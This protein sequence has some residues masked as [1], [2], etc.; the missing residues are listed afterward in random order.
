MYYVGCDQHKYYS[1]VTS[2]DKQGNIK[3]QVKLY[4]NDRDELVN[5]FSSLP[6]E[7]TVL[8]EASGFEPWLCDLLQGMGVN[9]KLAH[10]FKT[11]AIAEEKIKMD[12]LSSSVL[13]DLL[14][15]DLVCEAYIASPEIRQKRYRMRYR[16]SLVHLRTMT[17]NKIHSLLDRLGLQAPQ[18]TDLFGKSGRSYLEGLTL[19]SPYQ[20]ALD[21]YLALIDNLTVLIE[22]VDRELRKALKDDP[23]VK[24][25]TTIPGIGTILAH[26][27]LAEIGDINR[28][29]SSAKLAS[30]TGI[31]PSLH[32]SG[33]VTYLGSIT[34]QGNK[35]L[36]W[37]F[38]EA[39]HVAI[40]KDLYLGFYYGKLRHKK[41]SHIAIVAIAHKLLTYTYQVLKKQEPYKAKTVFGRA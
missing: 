15:A 11:R 36:R 21:G 12:K 4:H 28:F 10:P 1:Y 35:Y 6:K 31:I 13:S 18:Y 23:Q 7:S 24:L 5:Y 3:D 29:L 25:L 9:V 34:K 17:K 39:A 2:K 37:A 16:Q 38:V 19:P 40:R 30:Y 8:L 33:K 41:G 22:Q 14:R 20:K 32:Q 26:F 27:I